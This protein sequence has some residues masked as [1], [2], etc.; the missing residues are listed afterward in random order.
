MDNTFMDMWSILEFF[1]QH[2]DQAEKIAL[3]GREGA[4][5]VLRKKDMLVCVYRLLLEH[6]RI[7]DPNREDM[8]FEQDLVSMA[9]A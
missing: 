4:D 9:A 5:R 8:G 6:T 1:L 3:E 7:N 2:D